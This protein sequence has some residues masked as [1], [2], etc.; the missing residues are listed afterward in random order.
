[1]IQIETAG[2]K[3]KKGRTFVLIRSTKAITSTL[4]SRECP[5]KSC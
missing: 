5:Y 3:K 1:L 2:V 4:T